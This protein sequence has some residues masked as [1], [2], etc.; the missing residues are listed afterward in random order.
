MS[1]RRGDAPSDDRSSF[2]RRGRGD[3]ADDHG[4]GPRRGGGGDGDEPREPFKAPEDLPPSFLYCVKQLQDKPYEPLRYFRMQRALALRHGSAAHPRP[5]LI[6][7]HLIDFF[8]AVNGKYG[9]NIPNPYEL[10]PSII[11]ESIARNNMR[12]ERGGEGDD[13][14]HHPQPSAEPTTDAS[15]HHHTEQ[16]RQLVKLVSGGEGGN[17]AHTEGS[18]P[19]TIAPPP[20]DSAD[21][22]REMRNRQ[23]RQIQRSTMQPKVCMHYG[24]K[25]GCRRGVSCP[26]HHAGWDGSAATA[27]GTPVGLP[28]NAVELFRNATGR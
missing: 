18:H 12:R 3:E 14:P 23:L 25:E 9:V 11:T 4:H 1:S 17:V 15:H 6:Q 2:D 27:S 28:Q 19:P 26:F 24:S 22:M 20:M 7:R 21:A 10:V 8:V 13:A 5:H 16:H